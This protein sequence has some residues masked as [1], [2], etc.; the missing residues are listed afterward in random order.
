MAVNSPQPWS[1]IGRNLDPFG[2]EGG[3]GGGDVVALQ[4]QLGPAVLLGRLD[5]ELGRR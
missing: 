2:L 1:L 3:Y 5:G 4:V